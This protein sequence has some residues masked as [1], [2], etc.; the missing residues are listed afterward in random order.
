MAEKIQ[1]DNLSK[2]IEKELKLYSS[3]ITENI[4][5]VNDEC[6]AEF[7]QNTKRDAPRGRTKKK[8]YYSHITSTTTLETA[9]KKVNTWYVKDPKYRLTHLLKNGHATKNGG[10][11]KPQDFI[12]ENYENLEKNL[13]KKSEEVIKNASRKMV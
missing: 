7:V 12:T 9:N 8:K 13:E 11:T 10:R 3:E 5:K 1:I 2:K 6:M 4:K